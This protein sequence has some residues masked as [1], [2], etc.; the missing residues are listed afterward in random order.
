[1]KL[2]KDKRDKLILACLASVGLAGILYT[3]VLGA[4]KDHLGTL[5]RQLLTGRDKLEK[6]ERLIKSKDRFDEEVAT[7]QKILDEREEN[8]A[9]AGKYY[10][11]FLKLMDQFREQE[12]LN[13]AFIIDIT[14]PEFIEAGLVPKNPYKAASFGLRLAGPYQ[15]IGRFIADLENTFPYFRIQNI[16]MVPQSTGSSGG[17]SLKQGPSSG[18]QAGNGNLIVELRVV[19][20]IRG[21]TT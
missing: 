9:P 17:A 3:F 20:L 12:K 14:Q 10:Y 15:D 11:W 1:M 18:P 16:K 2:S 6:A 7:N 19:T 8:M 4:Q 5:Q 21:A 13:A